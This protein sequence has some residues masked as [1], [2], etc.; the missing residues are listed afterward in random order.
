MILDKL[1]P[2]RSTGL[3]ALEI[4]LDINC[5]VLSCISENLR[6]WDSV[7]GTGEGDG[8]A[9][10]GSG[11]GEEE[12]GA[13]PSGAQDHGRYALVTEHSAFTSLH[14][15]NRVTSLEQMY[16]MKTIDFKCDSGLLFL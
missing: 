4:F 3:W 2:S 7:R 14:S 1:V 5:F 11:G 8:S 16:V 6:A 12:H 15:L 13:R 10:S 9:P